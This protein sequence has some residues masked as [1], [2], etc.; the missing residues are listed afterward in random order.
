[1]FSW[2]L[3]LQKRWFSLLSSSVRKTREIHTSVDLPLT[4]F[5]EDRPSFKMQPSFL[6]KVVPLRQ[7]DLFFLTFLYA[8]KKHALFC[9]FKIKRVPFIFVVQTFSEHTDCVYLWQIQYLSRWMLCVS[10]FAIKL[11]NWYFQLSIQLLWDCWA[12]ELLYIYHSF[13]RHCELP[14]ELPQHLVESV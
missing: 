11:R 8:S 2:I 4:L 14:Q 7:F 10:V 12:T 3:L 13:P 1:M 6:L 5:F 9:I